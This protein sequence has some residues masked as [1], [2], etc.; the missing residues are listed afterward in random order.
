MSWN[1]MNGWLGVL[2]RELERIWVIKRQTIGGPLLETY[3]YITVF[4]AALGSRIR[5][6]DGF[7]YITF[8]VPGL[9]MMALAMNAFSNNS[10]SLMQQKMQ[11]AIDDQLTSPISH[12]GL[13]AAFTLGGFV[14][15]SVISA[16]TLI[17]A[18]FLIDLPIEHPLLLLASFIVIGLFF[19]SLGVLVGLQAK[20]FDN[21]SFYQTFIIQ[22]LIF[23]G[24][25]FYSTDLLSG[26]FKTL[27]EINPIHYMINT[28][29]YSMLGTA[30]VNPALA[31]PIIT[32]VTL[33][34]ITLNYQLF[35]RGYNLRA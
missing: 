9:A 3:L 10:S 28:V 11:H 12:G 21:L 17:T 29:R 32:V 5:E 26:V 23:L 33:G 31:L 20:V 7:S 14:R 15:G 30:D 27:V 2:R 4:G 34:L 13:L 1:G 22:P 25:V 8:I 6:L 35:K 19:A 18:S 24:G 16:L